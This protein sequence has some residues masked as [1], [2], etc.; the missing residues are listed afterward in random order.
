MAAGREVPGILGSLLAAVDEDGNRLTD[1]E[2]TDNLLLLMLAGHDTSSTTLTNVMAHVQDNRRV[3]DELRREQERV[4]A[5]RGPEITGAALKDMP[6]ADAVIRWARSALGGG[7]VD[8]GWAA[9]RCRSWAGVIGQEADCWLGLA[10][11]LARPRP[12]LSGAT[13]CS[14]PSVGPCATPSY[15]LPHP[16]AKPSASRCA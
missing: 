15:A 6:Y 9:P 14:H 1:S 5:R 12:S 4:V 13:T 8:A 11:P 7:G 16:L 10:W 2:L 3:L